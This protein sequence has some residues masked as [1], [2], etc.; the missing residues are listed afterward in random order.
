MTKLADSQRECAKLVGPGF[1]LEILIA[2]G[3]F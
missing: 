1:F 3:A 2:N